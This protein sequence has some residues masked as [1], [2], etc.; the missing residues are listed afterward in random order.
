LTDDPAGFGF[1]AEMLGVVVAP[2]GAKGALPLAVFIH[3]QSGT[4]YNTSSGAASVHWPCVEGE[5][6]V[7]SY[8]GYLP[9]QRYLAERGWLTLS[10]SLNGVGGSP[11]TESP[12]GDTVQ[13]TK[14]VEMHLR[15]W[16]AWAAGDNTVRPPAVLADVQPDLQRVMLIGHSRGGSAANQVALRSV[17]TPSS[18]WRVNAQ[19]LLSPAAAHFNPAPHVPTIVLLPGCDGDVTDLQGQSYIDRARDLG[20]DTALRSGVF[21]D[22]AN[23]TFFNTEWDPSTAVAKGA[24]KDDAG[25]LFEDRT[26]EGACRP[27]APER[28]SPDA[29]RAIASLYIAAAGRAFVLGDTTVLPLLDGSNVC[30]GASCGASIHTA[31]IGGKRRPLLIPQLDT[32]VSGDQISIAP[33]LTARDR[34]VE[35]GCITPDMK[36][37]KGL[38]RTP[39]FKSAIDQ[40]QGS[41]AQEPSQVALAIHWASK[42]HPVASIAAKG[43]LG[44]DATEVTVRVIADPEAVR[45][46]FELALVDTAG[47]TLPLGSA[48]LSGLPANA[49]P[50]TGV[51]W[52]QEARFAIDSRAMTDQGFDASSI[53]R[54]QLTALSDSGRIWLLDAWSY[55]PGAAPNTG[56]AARFEL[57]PSQ[58]TTDG[59]GDVRVAGSIIGDLQQAGELYYYLQPGVEGRVAVPAGSSSFELHLPNT[60]GAG[61]L[62]QL[63][64]VRGM[65]AGRKLETLESLMPDSESGL[66]TE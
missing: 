7:P 63:V 66:D 47:R 32:T 29:Q 34:G 27:G 1:P 9:F 14:L 50:G 12:T 18:P 53:A 39:H 38:T 64:G 40:P 25:A 57:L 56:A 21:I 2:V 49:G 41:V 8:R 15:Q 59:S 37:V 6:P 19:V 36:L 52:A 48:D 11:I 51:Y 61:T 54:L 35:G 28:L 55:A 58:F 62:V 17:T 42:D 24:A 44:Q 43:A 23:H 30:A 16:A 60:A 33:C 20:G 46:S 31:A 13:R 45:T 26:P 5:L 4:C 10:I 22:Y 3:G 65:V